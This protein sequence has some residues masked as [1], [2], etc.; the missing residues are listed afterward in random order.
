MTKILN[1]EP[2]EIYADNGI[3]WHK[4]S[5]KYVALG[6]AQAISGS[7]SLKSDKIEAYYNETKDS[8]MDIA[9][10]IAK[11]NV[12]I[13]DKKMKIIGGDFA[14][15]NIKKDYFK[16]NGSRLK[17]TSQKNILRSNV[18]SNKFSLTVCK[19]YKKIL[20]KQKRSLENALINTKE[21]IT[22]AYST[23]DT[24]AS[25]AN[26]V[27]LISQTQNTFNEIMNLQLPEIV[28]YENAELAMRFEEI[29]NRMI[30]SYERD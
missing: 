28:Q 1:N 22:V 20:E 13:Q 6:N 26:L 10:V 5:K 15:Y 19:D 21:Q 7:L 3:E 8:S 17:L 4:N 12:V 24:A 25:A 23:Y 29:S 27:N 16:V 14:E 11:R 9:N 18:S 30:E 2:I